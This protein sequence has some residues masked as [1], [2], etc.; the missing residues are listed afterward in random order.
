MWRVAAAP[1]RSLLKREK[2]KGPERLPGDERLD[3]DGRNGNDEGQEHA[4]ESETLTSTE[5]W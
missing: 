3:V 1:R 4:E 5:S 2:E